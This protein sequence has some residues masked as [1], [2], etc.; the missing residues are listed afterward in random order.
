MSVISSVDRLISGLEAFKATVGSGIPADKTGE[1]EVLFSEAS[2]KLDQFAKSDDTMN[3]ANT[4]TDSGEASGETDL[5]SIQKALRDTY[6][7]VTNDDGTFS[8]QYPTGG[9][10]GTYKSSEMAERMA[11]TLEA[12]KAAMIHAA[13]FQIDRSVE[14][15]ETLRSEGFSEQQ[16]DAAYDKLYE[17]KAQAQER[18][19]SM[20]KTEATRNGNG[21]ALQDVVNFYR[22]LLPSSVLATVTE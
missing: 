18:L 17:N 20:L 7:V 1:F 4:L 11:T 16:I 6:T 10:I 12:G 21:L 13:N 9:F 5:M 19:T 14:A 8:V 2:S 3:V 22:P 15:E